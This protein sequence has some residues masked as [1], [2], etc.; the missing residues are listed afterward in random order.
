[1]NGEAVFTGPVQDIRSHYF[2]FVHFREQTAARV[3]NVVL[4]GNWP[5]TV[6]PAD[7]AFATAPTSPTIARV[8]RELIG[9]G[10]FEGDVKDVLASVA[11]KSPAERYEAL[12]AWVLPSET[13]PR[14]QLATITVPQDVLGVVDQAN[15]PAG[16]R[17]LLGNKIDAPALQLVAA[18]KAAG[19]LD[20]LISR[21][22]KASVPTPTETFRNAKVA[23]MVAVRVAQEKADEANVLLKSMLE[24]ATKLPLNA[25]GKTRQPTYFAA[26]AAAEQKSTAAA[27]LAIAQALNQNLEESMNKNQ[28]FDG[29]DNWMRPYRAVRVRAE[30]T[31]NGSPRRS[32]PGLRH[33]GAVSDINSWTRSQGFDAPVWTVRDG[34]FLHLPGH[35]EDYLILKTP[36]AGDFEVTCDLYVRGW[37]EGHIRYGGYQF[38]LNHD[39]KSYKLHTNVR[40]AGTATTIL[41]PLPESKA[42]TYAFKMTVKDGVMTCSVDGRVL[43][44]ERIGAKPDPWL[45]LHAH[46]HCVGWVKNLKLNGQPTVPASIDLLVQ[47]SLACWRPHL[48]TDWI[49]RGEEMYHAGGKPIL[50]PEEK[51]RRYFPEASNYYQ[52]PMFED[53][54]V[55]YEFYYEPGKAAVFPSLDRLGF[56]F[57]ET[58]CKLH[59]M[60]DGPHEKTGIPFDNVM[61]DP[62]HRKAEK[63]PLTPKAWNKAALTV[64]GDVVRVTVNG[65]AVYERPI[66]STNQRLFGFYH[67]QD[68]TEARVRNV[69][70]TGDW[71]KTPPKSEELLTPK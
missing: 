17:V 46:Y 70:H 58:G 27:A 67:Y 60:T 24:V 22:D 26:L 52:R 55:E 3:R 4:T 59:W 49:K 71:A 30:L 6:A 56:E 51:E 36:L 9:E 15:Q 18:A 5:K 48:N 33:W 53:G 68:R 19:K 31:L 14:I 23:L 37:R 64:Q 11:K 8:R 25:E 32:D 12:A 54:T 63:I 66:E 39:K 43:S 44:T 57:D 65:V 1:V 16:E 34:A 69:I 62:K 2:G 13:R 50:P 45:T 28:P 20:D 10:Y 29:R 7:V 35:Q 38:D 42:E 21:I 47:D 61:V 41:P 40:H